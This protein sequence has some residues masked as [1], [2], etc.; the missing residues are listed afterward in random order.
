MKR[1]CYVTIDLNARMMRGRGQK[2]DIFLARRSLVVWC[3]AK[4]IE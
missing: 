2:R 1:D 3:V 4:K